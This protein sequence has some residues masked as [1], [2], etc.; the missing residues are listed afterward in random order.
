M[1]SFRKTKIL[2]LV[3]STFLIIS[4]SNS[5]NSQTSSKP[6]PS[7]TL[8]EATFK[9]KSECD[10]DPFLTGEMKQYEK[11]QKGIFPGGITCFPTLRYVIKDLP[12]ETPT[13]T[14]TPKEE[15]QPFEKCDLKRYNEIWLHDEKAGYHLSPNTVIQIIPFQ[16]VDYPANGDP[17]KELSTYWKFLESSLDNMTDVESK[18]EVRIADK[19]FKIDKYLKDYAMPPHDG[20]YQEENGVTKIAYEVLKI[21]DKDINF[22]DV[23]KIYLV[24]PPGTNSYK[25]VNWGG[26]NQ[27]KTD[28]GTIPGIYI[29]G[30]PTTIRSGSANI[31]GPMGE[32]H[33][34][35]HVMAGT[36]FDHDAALTGGYGN[37]SGA[38]GDFMVWDK[39]VAK[40]IDG[41]QVRC[42]PTDKT[43]TH[44]IKPSTINGKHEKLLMIPISDHEAIA[45]ESVRG[46]GFNFK[47]PSYRFGALVY[48][49]N[50]KK[51][52]V[53]MN[54]GDGIEVLSNPKKGYIKMPLLPGEFRDVKGYKI[55][56]LESGEFGDVIQVE[57]AV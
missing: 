29:S 18:Y 55:T 5:T 12:S 7:A 44:W 45:V 49:I 50:T 36:L 46:S 32:V 40:F 53:K 54:G 8:D 39:L 33:E 13:T 34:I 24:G 31:R 57:P 43:S 25:L 38:F 22:K 4:C 28:E 17:V 11:D 6:S 41:E 47:L 14:Q 35:M 27:I 42:A 56:V 48:T 3:L 10:E 15:L 30:H 16:T 1:L 26:S 20:P 52:D 51:M 21:A 9:F 23:N 2:S 37:M 19:Y